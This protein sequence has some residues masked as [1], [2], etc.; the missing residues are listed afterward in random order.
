[1]KVNGIITKIAA[2][3]VLSISAILASCGGSSMNDSMDAAADT[4]AVSS[5][6]GGNG[7]GNPGI[8]GGGDENERGTSSYDGY[9]VETAD[10]AYADGIDILFQ[11][12]KN[13]MGQYKFV[14]KLT[15]NSAHARLVD[16]KHGSLNFDFFVFQNG[17]KQWQ[18]SQDSHC[19]EI[20]PDF[21]LQ[22]YQTKTY[23]IPWDGRNLANHV[24]SGLATVKGKLYLQS[25]T[26]ILD[27][28]AY[29]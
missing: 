6:D 15:N 19:L 16:F 2:V 5:I 26:V 9:W 29:L 21:H 24:M 8:D 20:L 27:G 1:M 13:S 7:N 12:K 18:A 4:A 22:P 25:G 10:A 14:L 11:L 17:M 23:E 3:A 28:P